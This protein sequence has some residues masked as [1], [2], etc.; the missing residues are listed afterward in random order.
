MDKPPIFHE[1]IHNNLPSYLF[2]RLYNSNN[3]QNTRNTLYVNFNAF[4]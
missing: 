2:W 3:M 4:A 1:R